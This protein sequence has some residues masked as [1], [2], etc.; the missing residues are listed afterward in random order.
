MK[1]T[2]LVHTCGMPLF[3][4]RLLTNSQNK[5]DSASWTKSQRAQPLSTGALQVVHPTSR[6]TR[7]LKGFRKNTSERTTTGTRKARSRYAECLLDLLERVWSR[8][9]FL[10]A[11]KEFEPHR[12]LDQGERSGPIRLRQKYTCR[13]N[14][15]VPQASGS[16]TFGRLEGRRP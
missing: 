14:R 8:L 7:F 4:I 9:D 1:I 16:L 5:G 11:G 15:A 3:L 12:D 6:P 2:F 13:G 10:G